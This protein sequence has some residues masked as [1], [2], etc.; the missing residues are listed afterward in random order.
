MQARRNT[1]PTKIKTPQ[2]PRG[3]PQL[4]RDVKNE[5]RTD[6]VYENIGNG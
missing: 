6:Y 1:A 2:G 5:G 4:Q 3:T